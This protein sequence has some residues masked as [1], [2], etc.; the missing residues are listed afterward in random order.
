M[1][2][3]EFGSPPIADELNFFRPEDIAINPDECAIRLGALAGRD[4]DD[5]HIQARL[6]RLLE[7]DTVLAIALSDHVRHVADIEYEQAIDPTTGLKSFSELQ[8]WIKSTYGLTES[9]EELQRRPKEGVPEPRSC[10]VIASDIINFKRLNDSL[11][12][13]VAN[14]ALGLSAQEL[15]G[16]LRGGDHLIA[17]RPNNKRGDEKLV[18]AADLSQKETQM[19][20]RRLRELQLRKTF[21]H[22]QQ[23]IWQAVEEAQAGCPDP[24]KPLQ[25]VRLESE[26]NGAQ[27]ELIVYIHD[28][29]IAP[30]LDMTV[31]AFG[32]AFG[33]GTSQEAI[34]EIM[35]RAHGDMQATKDVMHDI[36]GGADRA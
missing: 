12:E 32:W 6:R 9:P 3:A 25:F 27:E 30:L 36:V 17:V 23:R 29:R 34:D 26:E 16:R 19:L 21:D 24:S 7:G 35:K 2:D 14:R 22:G 10:A 28:T 11:G 4:P 15:Q 18:V 31:V 13:W 5:P 8:R 1:V 20:T 33:N